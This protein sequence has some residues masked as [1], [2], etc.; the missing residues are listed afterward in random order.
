MNLYELMSEC[1]RYY[2][3]LH[4]QNGGRL[5]KPQM[6]QKTAHIFGIQVETLRWMIMI[7]GLKP[8]TRYTSRA[9]FPENA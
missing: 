9:N 1:L 5:S 7:D 6:Q 8:T 2:R 3:E 4:S